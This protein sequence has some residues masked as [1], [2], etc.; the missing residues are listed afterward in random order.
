MFDKLVSSCNF[1]LNNFAPAQP[2]KDYLNQRLSENSQT[3]FQFGYFPNINNLPALTSLIDE[4]PLKT[5]NFY[6]LKV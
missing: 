2:V 3:I 5:L 6:I 4:S 1:L